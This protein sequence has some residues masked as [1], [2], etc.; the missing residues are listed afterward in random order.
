MSEPY[1]CDAKIPAGTIRIARRHVFLCI[2]PDCCDPAL[3]DEIWQILK[4]RVAALGL[5]TL[6]TKA[7]CLRIC[8]SGPWLVVEP[9]GVWYGG[10]TP[11]RLERILTEHVANGRPVE[12][13]VAVRC[14]WR[15]NSAD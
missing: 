4:A 5:P 12:E 13:W 6:R 3:G 1:P 7:S 14:G 8:R 15:G 10:I 11:E 2:G 9:D